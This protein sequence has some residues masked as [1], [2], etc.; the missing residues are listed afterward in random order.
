MS[1]FE[2]V[3]ILENFK[4]LSFIS[5]IFVIIVDIVFDLCFR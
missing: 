2:D 4:I 3:K 5:W 1:G